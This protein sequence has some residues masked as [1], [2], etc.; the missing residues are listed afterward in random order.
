MIYSGVSFFKT[1]LGENWMDPN[2]VLWL[3]HYGRPPGQPG[4]LSPRV[5]IHQYSDAGKIP[6]I[7]GNVDL[8]CAIWPLAK[9][10]TGEDAE[11]TPEEHDALMLVETS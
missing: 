5:A 7:T 3:A 10:I 8:N 11:L 1:Q 9:I 4:Y 6:G 2:M